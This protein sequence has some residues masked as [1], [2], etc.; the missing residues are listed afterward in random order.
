M[1]ANQTKLLTCETYYY[2]VLTATP[3]ANIYYLQGKITIKKHRYTMSI[4]TIIID[5]NSAQSA[6]E[7]AAAQQALQEIN[8]SGLVETVRQPY[9]TFKRIQ[10]V[11]ET[12]I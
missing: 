12:L 5:E 9:T 4:V 8:E 11:L 10:K 3:T 1:T 2:D 7:A 6:I